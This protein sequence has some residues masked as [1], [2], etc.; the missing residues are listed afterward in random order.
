MSALQSGAATTIALLAA[1]FG[2][3]LLGGLIPVLNVELYLVSAAT[4]A[5]RCLALSLILLAA[6]G[7]MVAKSSLYLAGRGAAGLPA[8]LRSKRM[9]AAAERIRSRQ[10]IGDLFLFGSAVTGL[11]PFYAVS[12][13][14]GAVKVPF[15]RFLVLGLFGRCL[16][17]SAVVLAP[18]A[19]R[20]VWP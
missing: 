8:R 20:G 14:S 10:R 19:L 18:Q 9:Q 13:A 12:I 17:F 1:T 4:V 6:S 2:F 16:R 15:A 11:P 7:Q 3:S 5:P